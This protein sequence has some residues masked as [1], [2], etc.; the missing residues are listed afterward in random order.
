MAEAKK[1]RTK[2]PKT[3]AV[4]KA[5]PV[6]TT[7]TSVK[8]STAK[9]T[10]VSK[11]DTSK[12]RRNIKLPKFLQGIVGYFVGSWKEIKMVNWPNRKATWSLTLAV[13]LFTGFWT[14]VVLS[15]DLL[16]QYLLNNLILK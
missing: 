16:N 14:A 4:K 2:K 9:K 11:K 13:L 3:A 7:V 12:K 8:T 10:A 15:L 5:K 1:V 6:K